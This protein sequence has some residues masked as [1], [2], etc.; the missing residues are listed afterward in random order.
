MFISWKGGNLC[1]IMERGKSVLYHGK[2]EICVIPWKRSYQGILLMF[3]ERDSQVAA[4]LLEDWLSP[5][6][7]AWLQLP[8]DSVASFPSLHGVG[9]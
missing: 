9:L 6:S 8:G 4:A 2:D 1:Y 3:G 7:S 5:C